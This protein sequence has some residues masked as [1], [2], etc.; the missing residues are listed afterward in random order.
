MRPRPEDRQGFLSD[1][2]LSGGEGRRLESFPLSVPAFRDPKAI[3]LHSAVTFFIGESGSG[4]STL[5]EA[6]AAR[7]GFEELGGD[8]QVGNTHRF[9]H[10]APDG[11]L[12]DYLQ[13]VS[14]R[15]RRPVDRFFMRAETVFDL[16][17]KLERGQEQD[18]GSLDR[19]GGVSLHTRS[20]G[21]AFLAIVQNRMR[22]ETLILMDEP[23]AA[24]TY[25]ATHADQRDRLAR[26]LRLSA[27]R[28]HPLTILMAH[29]DSSMYE[30]GEFGIRPTAYEK[31]EHYQVT[32]SFLNSPGSYLRHLVE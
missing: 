26:P 13:I 28:C 8:A 17:S 7:L 25:S 5:I 15:H 9:N 18:H 11:G 19:F 30:M 20:H 1:I 14:H 23:E 16:A 3:E 24:L 6:V 4:K 21:E 27:S 31:T 10:L 22:A 29:P 12:H 2:L 32:T